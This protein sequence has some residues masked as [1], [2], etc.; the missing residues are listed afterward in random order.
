MF[1][2]AL[3]GCMW[4]LRNGWKTFKL[5]FLLS[6]P[7]TALPIFIG[8]LNG[9]YFALWND[10]E[11]RRNSDTYLYE[12]RDHLRDW[13]YRDYSF[14]AFSDTHNYMNLMRLNTNDWASKLGFILPREY[15]ELAYE[16]D[17][18]ISK[19]ADLET[20]MY[21]ANDPALCEPDKRAPKEQWVW[22]TEWGWP[23]IDD[24]DAALVAAM[25]EI[26]PSKMNQTRIFFVSN[27]EGSGSGTGG[28]LAGVW[29]VRAPTLMHFV[30][31]DEAPEPEDIPS[32]VTYAADLKDLRRVTTRVIDLPLADAYTGLPSKT[33]PGKKEQILSIMNGDR[34]WEQFEPWNE[35]QQMLNRF[36]E[37]NEI[38]FDRK[39]T[40]NY[41][42]G[43]TDDWI[44]D[45][46]H[47]RLGLVA[48]MDGVSQMFFLTGWLSMRGLVLFPWNLGKEMIMEYL[49]H[50]K[51]GDVIVGDL[52]TRKRVNPLD[53]L[54]DGMS[55]EL[56]KLWADAAA[57]ENNEKIWPG[58]SMSTSSTMGEG[59]IKSS[60]T[61]TA[62]G[63]PTEATF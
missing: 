48:L 22:I 23:L 49:G 52:S 5:L 4:L 10:A 14:R 29:A 55:D 30:I 57:K 24:W 51:R 38:V 19:Y 13:G 45:N 28:F 32:G 2:A 44:T 25:S 43:E 6:L 40:I 37:H 15:T 46:I 7:L 61:T 54:M 31:E 42:I 12:I 27:R 50:P 39:G 26:N 58:G 59:P 34:L 56:K 20:L 11:I 62:S 9:I 3:S 63:A 8:I 47:E 35:L 53:F 36:N 41:Y 16:V 60:I 18:P 17:P 33:F 1:R 21:F